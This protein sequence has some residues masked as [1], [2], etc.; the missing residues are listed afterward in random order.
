MHL[1][2]C[3]LRTGKIFLDLG[4]KSGPVNLGRNR[5]TPEDLREV[6]NLSEN[7]RTTTLISGH[8]YLIC[9]APHRRLIGIS[10]TRGDD[11]ISIAEDADSESK[12]R[13]V[14]NGTKRVLTR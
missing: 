14:N 3:A 6:G 11:R 4:V 12:K 9:Q 13:S 5:N 10:Q 1:D 2:I 7:L 8:W